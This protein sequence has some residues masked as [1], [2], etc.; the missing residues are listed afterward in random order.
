MD[1]SL[2][3]QNLD[4]FGEPIERGNWVY[5]IDDKLYIVTESYSSIPNA[6]YSDLAFYSEKFS[7]I[8]TISILS[9]F[10][11]KVDIVAGHSKEEY[12][13]LSEEYKSLVR[14]NK[15]KNILKISKND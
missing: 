1:L 5:G 14:K 4:M 9:K 12:K 7:G 13:I 15:L 8:S 2:E 11:K 6:A 10:L 3:E